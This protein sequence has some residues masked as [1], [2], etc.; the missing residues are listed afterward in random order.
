MTRLRTL[1]DA[2]AD[3]AGS[4]E[5]YVFAGAAAETRRSYAE[6]HHASRSAAAAFHDLGLGRGDL[7][8]LVVDE[9]EE[10]LT[11]LFGAS[12]AGLIPASL[13]PPSTSTDRTRYLAA[14]AGILR[15]S[16]ARA[17]V[18]T[19]R[20][21]AD[22]EEMRSSC[23][24]L[25]VVVTPEALAAPCAIG[26]GRPAFNVSLDDI[27][28]VQFTS[29]ST[30]APKGV[31]GDAPQPRG[32]H[33]G[34]QRSRGPRVVSVGLGGELAA[35]V[36]TTW[37]WSAWRWGRCTAPGPAVL[38]DAAGVREAASRLAARDLASPCHRELRA[39]FRLRPVR[40][41]NQGA[42]SRRARSVVLACGGMRR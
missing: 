36:L 28:F 2:L 39:Q 9:A 17:V 30:S 40:A 25:E 6:I 41:P 18:T 26:S 10:F 5:G 19:A 13:Y 24:D 34:H 11:T 21:V 38:D 37:D 8:A 29:G 22:F 20:L 12:I 32:E 15:G 35:A 7:V 14:T 4:G 31:A 27:A 23:P 3:A 33:R 1:P 16:R 42:R